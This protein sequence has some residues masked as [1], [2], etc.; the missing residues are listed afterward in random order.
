MRPFQKEALEQIEAALASTR[1]VILEAPV[2]FGKS[3]V[4]A[5]LCRY[6]RSAHI[7]TATKQLQDQYAFD[8]G[9]P[10][11]KGKSNFRCC[12]PNSSGTF[13]PCSKGR[14]EVD[15]SLKDCPHYIT[16][17]EYSAHKRRLCTSDSKCECL[18]NGKLCIYYD[19]KWSGFRAP[20]T[21]YNY[22]FLLSEL[23]YAGDVPHRKL[24][25]CD[26]VHDLEKQIVGFA[27][28]SL[29]KPVLQ[30][31]HDE[32]RPREEFAIPNKGFDDSAAWLDVLFGMKEMLKEYFAL[33]CEAGH[34]QDRAATCK[35][36]IKDLDIFTENLQVDPEN[37]VVNSV[38]GA[39]D[40]SVEEVVFQPIL[41][42]DYTFPLFNVAGSVLL[43]S[44]TV[45]SKERLCRVL[46]IKE[47]E[48]SF[49]PI[50]ESTFPVENRPIY[51]LNTVRLNRASMD[52]A[53]ARITRVIDEIMVRHTWERGVIHTTSYLQANYIMQHVSESNR[54]RLVTTEGGFDRSAL[55]QIHSSSDA[56]VLI[57]PS[58]YQGVDLKDESSRFQVI[59]K[60]PYPDL[61]QRRIVVKLQRDREWYDW[62]TALRLVQTYGRSVR[63]EDDHAVTY[64]LDSNFTHFVSIHRNLFPKFFLEAL[65]DGIQVL[66]QDQKT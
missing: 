26:E 43:M 61:S 2:G 64:V 25:V 7:L 40:G 63:S 21:V 23:K 9:F 33:H 62:Q 54:A 18:K 31:Y 12:I 44:A 48:V 56:S 19:Q 22:P 28:F 65:K 36:M 14:C 20:I 51:A 39:G 45:F 34:E 11:I 59:V 1:F 16:F 10:V 15:W 46:G 29:K 32:I 3:A 38:K 47:Q 57:S 49:I 6:L 17:E 24:L 4:A 53:L 50:Y 35:D 58:L 27:S 60:V 13:M 41:V 5:S 30:S 55:M 8:F 66:P 52:V 42:G 37:W